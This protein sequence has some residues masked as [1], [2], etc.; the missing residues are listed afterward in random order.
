MSTPAWPWPNFS[1]RE[2]GCRHCHTALINVRAMDAL[3]SLRDMMAHPLTIN[4]AYRC[5]VHN[6]QVGGAKT[7]YHLKGE[8]FDISTVHV[9]AKQ[10]RAVAEKAGFTGFGTYPT[11][12][13]VDIGPAREWFGK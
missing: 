11:F 1:L 5:P 13:H 9:D 2:I 6:A 8:A 7:S 4:S 10:L 12:L 3:Q